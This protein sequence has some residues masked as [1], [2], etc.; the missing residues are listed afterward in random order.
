MTDSRDFRPLSDDELEAAPQETERSG[1][2]DAR[3]TTA[4]ADAEPGADAA[5]RLFGRPPDAIWRYGD[6]QGAIAFHVCRWNRPNGEKDIR[7]LSWFERE[8][9]R[10]GAW[11]NHRPL[12]NLEKIVSDVDAP[13]VVAEGE[14][15]A[16]ATARVFPKSIATTSS[17]GAQAARKTDWTPLGGRR[18]L[19]WPDNDEAG[20]KYA[21]E[22]ATILAALDCD[23]SIVDSAKLARINLNCG[24]LALANGYD[25]AD[26]LTEWADAT[27]LRRAAVSLAGPFTA[28]PA[29]VSFSRYSMDETG[30]TI[31]P[32]GD[33]VD[34]KRTE[35]GW[36]A[37]PFEVLGRCRD[38]NGGAWGKVLRWRDADGREHVRHIQDADLYGP[39]AAL[40]SNLSGHGLSI[41]RKRQGELV[42]Y[43][44]AVNVKR[45][46]TIVSRTGWHEVGGRRVFV[47]P[48][49]TIGPR[50][51]ERVILDALAHAGYEARGTIEEW[52][53]GVGKLASG[54]VLAVLAISA[55]LAGPLLYLAGGEG[56][57]VH[58]F[59]QSSKGKT[60]ILQAAASVWGS[61]TSP[62]V[63]QS[64]ARNGERARGRGSAGDGYRPCA[65]RNGRS[66]R[67]RCWRGYLRLG[68]RRR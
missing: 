49:E 7:P 39:P 53:A 63:C 23:V 29:Y 36:I 16:E 47:L 42:N 12:L 5:A 67:A 51:A 6:E 60:T 21:L 24:Q 9:W 22:V 66:R 15:A 37:T 28:G 35:T 61:G 64:V 44:A 57:G 8:G 32:H 62:G 40:C 25:V 41:A 31:E 27:A 50:G 38:L 3:P 19:I 68:Q 17:G 14:K 58:L 46:V 43:L 48:N 45:R 4:P 65:G 59:G 11:P 18:V 34:G 1:G 54:H 26:A 30:L 56:G 20:E 55:A 13:I 52:R 10:F 2:R 33:N